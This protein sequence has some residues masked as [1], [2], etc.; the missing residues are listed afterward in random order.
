MAWLRVGSHLTFVGVELMMISVRLSVLS[1]TRLYEYA[2]R[3]VLG[4]AITMLAGLIAASFGPVIGGLFLAFPAIFPASATLVEK[5]ELERKERHGLAGRRRGKE[6]AALEAAGAVMGSIGLV[7][8]G[9]IA[10]RLTPPLSGFA[11]LIAAIA[12]L[13]VSVLLW[14]ARRPVRI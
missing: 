7:A 3:F 13:V 14:L 8:F 4:G 2:I 12:W 10:W 5:H 9:A 1:Q 6:A 11:L